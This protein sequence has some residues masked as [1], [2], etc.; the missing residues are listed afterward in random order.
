[1]RLSLAYTIFMK[2]KI[3]IK[4]LIVLA[5]GAFYG[6]YMH[7][8]YDKWHILGHDAFIAYQSHRFDHYMLTPMSSASLI[9]TYAILVLGLGALYE[10]A[11]YAGAKL[12]DLLLQRKSSGDKTVL[13]S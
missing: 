13:E 7:T 10:G 5:V 12:I 3:I 11:A 2:Y 6:K 1:M 8:Y 9:I 4:F